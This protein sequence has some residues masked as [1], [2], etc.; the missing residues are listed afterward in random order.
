MDIPETANILDSSK[1]QTYMRCPRRFLFQYIL[2]WQPEAPSVDLV[3][4]SAW[5][6]GMEALIAGNYTPDAVI[7]ATNAF[8][9]YYQSHFGP[10]WE[11]VNRPKNLSNGLRGL[12]LYADHY[13]REDQDLELLYSEVAGSVLFGEDPL[14]FKMDSVVKCPKRGIIA[15][16]RKTAGRLDSRWA[17]QWRLKFQVSLYTYALYCLYGDEHLYGLI[18]DGF[19]PHDPPRLKKDG[20]PYANSRDC[21]F[22]RIPARRSPET[23]DAWVIQCSLL[24]SEI[25]QDLDLLSTASPDDQHLYCFEQRTE[26]C[27]DFR[28]CPFLD[29][30]S[31]GKNPLRWAEPPS[32]MIIN[33]WDPRDITKNSK[34]T[35]SLTPK[36]GT[37]L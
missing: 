1:I 32:G 34:E 14:Y 13:R 15:F 35:V 4:G 36:K 2:G 31:T 18:L 33:H 12:I 5:H 11:D 29:F 8:T 27:G 3:F 37:S 10:E 22:L 17:N 19:S 21:E 9:E 6:E 28:G 25:H 7:K 23:L 26:S 30:C 20:T 24:L 16:E